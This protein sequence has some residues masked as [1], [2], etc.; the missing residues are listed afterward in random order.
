MNKLQ[1]FEVTYPWL[2]KSILDSHFFPL[3][4]ALKTVL[5]LA[6]STPHKNQLS[7]Y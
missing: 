7:T 4:T 3:Q 6:Q 1:I 2:P 5:A